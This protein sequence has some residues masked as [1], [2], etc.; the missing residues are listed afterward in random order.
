MRLLHALGDSIMTIDY[1]SGHRIKSTVC[2]AGT[3]AGDKQR[4]APSPAHAL[5]IRYDSSI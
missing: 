1:M 4:L 5:C 2:L 3:A